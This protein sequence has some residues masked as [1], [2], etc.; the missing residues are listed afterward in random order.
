MWEIIPNPGRIRIYTS[1][2]PKNQNRCW[3]RIGSPPPMGSKKLELIL[4][5]NNNMVIAPARTGKERSRRIAV[6]KIDQ[7]R[8]GVLLKLIFLGFIF[9]MVVIKLIAP[10]IEDPPAKWREKIVRSTDGP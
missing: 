7:G 9:K 10:M 2:C 4:R 3:K 5:S 6:I 1:G 8:R